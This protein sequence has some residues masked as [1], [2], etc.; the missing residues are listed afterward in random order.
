MFAAYQGRRVGGFGEIACFSTYVAHLLVTGVGGLAT[1]NNPE[2]AVRMRSL[3]NHGRDSIY[4]NIDDDQ[5]QS[6]EELHVI[7]ARRFRFTSIGHSF[8]ATELQAA[9]GLAQFE[10]WESIIKARRANARSLV[11]KLQHLESKLQLPRVRDGSESSFMMFPMVLREEP[12]GELVDFLERRGVETRSMLPI[13]NQP[14]YQDLL[15][16]REDTHP[17]AK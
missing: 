3:V 15:G 16:W 7:V 8:R 13:T 12:K 14:V 2:Y 1:T 5:G 11:R 6:D 9:L 17:V 4:L 10:E